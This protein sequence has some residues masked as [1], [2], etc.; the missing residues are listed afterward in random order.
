MKSRIQKGML[1]G[2]AATVVVSI[3]DVAASWIQSA[4]GVQQAWFHSFPTLLAAVANE[5][6]GLPN[7]MWVGW[8]FH[9][10][11]GVLVLG[12]VFG[13]LCPKLPTD[14]PETKG[15]F[16]AVAAWLVMMLTVMPL[17]PQLG[18]FGVGAGFGT[19][20]WMLVTHVLFGIV[21]GAVYAWLVEREKRAARPAPSATA[22]A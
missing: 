19:V 18:V 22:H 9:F 2:L 11:A 5:V 4:M 13:V 6:I 1:A 15:I 21:L 3:V 12:P 14:T 20:I 17:H 10:V 8:L 16:F 7:A